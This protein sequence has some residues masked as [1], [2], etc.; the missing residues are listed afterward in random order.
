[1]LITRFLS[2]GVLLL[3]TLIPTSAI[4]LELNNGKTIFEKS[5][6]LIEAATSFRKKNS[7]L[8][9][10]HFIIE[11][12]ANSGEPLKAIQIEQQG[13]SRQDIIFKPKQ[14]R[15][16]LGNIHTDGNEQ[17]LLIESIP[18]EEYSQRKITVIFKK[19]ILPGN[20][21]TIT[22]KPKN[23]P[24]LRGSYLFGITAYPQGKDSQGL[25]L[26]SRQINITK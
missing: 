21:V 13:N 10:Y 8:A 19:P 22:I 6:L 24:R 26:G 4:A 7:S 18:D 14:S 11:V 16:F 17:A 20:T 12:P 15:A 5:P 2:T 3:N 23:N 9:T 1:M 25:Y